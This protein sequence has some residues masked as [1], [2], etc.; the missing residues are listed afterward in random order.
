MSQEYIDRLVQAYPS[1]REIWLL[2]SRANGTE[3][4]N[5]DWDYLAFGDD[6]R[7][8]ND[9]HNDIQ[10][11]DPDVD[12]LFLSPGADEA[13]KPWLDPTGWKKLGLGDAPGGIKW[14]VTSPSEATY[15]ESKERSPGS[16]YSDQRTVK[17]RR[18]YNRGPTKE[19]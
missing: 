10:F 14:R 16:F 3:R 6:A 2:G 9:L 13:I 11:N 18:V 4:Q 5:S 15:V 7:A 12:L 19:G 8:F 1:I 17:A